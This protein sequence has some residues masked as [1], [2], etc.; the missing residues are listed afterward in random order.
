MASPAATPL[1]SMPKKPGFAAR[2]LYVTATTLNVRTRPEPTA[3]VLLSVPKGTTVVA[4]SQVDGWY[5][6]RLTDGSTGWMSAS[7]LAAAAPTEEASK[8]PAAPEPPKKSFNRAA[9]I[10]AI[11][12]LS[13]RSYSGNCPCPYNVDRGGG[14]AGV[15][16]PIHGQAENPRYATP[17]M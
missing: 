15:A 4:V 12:S 16:A 9:V 8:P 10:A 13:I 14:A 7:Y 1:L 3:N 2:T 5:E 11:I 17:R 6:V